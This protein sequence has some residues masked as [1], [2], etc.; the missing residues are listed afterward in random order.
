MKNTK[1]R[2][3]I[4]IPVYNEERCLFKSIEK[5]IKYL[6]RAKFP[7]N[8]EIIIADN[9]SVDNT[10]REARKLEKRYSHVKYFRIEKKGRGLALR[11][12]W[13]KVNADVMSY[14]DVDLSTDLKHIRP[15]IES[16]I[17][18]KND[19][20]IGNRL[21]K[22]SNVID[23]TLKREILSRTYNMILKAVFWYGI[24]DYQCGFKAVDKKYFMKIK[25]KIVDNKWFFD[26]E[27]ILLTAFN[28]RKIKQVSVKWVDDY[29]SRVKLGSTIKEYLTAIIRVKKSMIFHPKRLLIKK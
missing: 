5:L 26:T 27:L 4:T 21:A 23:R 16:I 29:D 9:A 25:D 11:T 19:L 6:K 20:S 7:Y 22:D 24:T 12:V 14:M 28:K 1:I 2:V 10:P 15:L 3:N 13:S 17:I 8:Y 18:D